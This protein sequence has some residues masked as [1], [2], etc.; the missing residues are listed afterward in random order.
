M[1]H[2]NCASSIVTV[3]ENRNAEGSLLVHDEMLDEIVGCKRRDER[4]VS[5]QLREWISLIS[6]S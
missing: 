4:V 6:P 3:P 5:S 2:R 1:E